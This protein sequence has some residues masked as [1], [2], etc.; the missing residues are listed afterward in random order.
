MRKTIVILVMALVVMS[1]VFA[2]AAT[3]T[4]EAGSLEH[5]DFL[6]NWTT[7]ADHS[8][9]YVALKNG[10]YKEAGLD[11]NV[12]IGQGSGYSVQMVDAGKADIAISD[13]PVVFAY[14]NEGANV[15]IIGT[16]FD[17]HPNT[18]WFWKDSGI[19]KPQDIVGKL[20]AV[21][22]TDG[23]KVMWPAFAALIGVNPDSVNFLNVEASGKVAALSSRNADVSFD[24]LTGIA[25]YQAAIGK[26]NLGYFLWADYGYQCYAHSYIASDDTI[27]KRGD[28]LKKFLDVTYRSWEW[29]ITHPEEAIEILSEYQPINKDNLLTALYI[30][31]SFIM[32]DRFKEHGIGY[33]DPAGMQSTYNLVNDYQT[34]LNFKVTDVYDASFLPTKKY[35]N[36]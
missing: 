10:W 3:E 23:H 25:N 31:Q 12:I 24:L 35:N 18:M 1:M 34:K 15:K 4:K 28:V 22:P 32:T 14:R 19:T 30:E 27:A 20:V 33:I 8:P 13:A 16:I 26:E 7:T 6:L 9:Y 21:P 17:K 2:N 11:V 29:C 36:I 5:I